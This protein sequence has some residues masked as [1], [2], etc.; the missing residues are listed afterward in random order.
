MPS[1]EFF[2][3][4]SQT[5]NM[6]GWMVWL[7]AL[8]IGGYVVTKTLVALPP[9]EGRAALEFFTRT[10]EPIVI[11][12][13]LLVMSSAVMASTIF[14]P[15]DSIW[16]LYATWYGRT[17]VV[18]LVLAVMMFLRSRQRFA[19]L[20]NLLWDKNDSLH[21]RASAIVRNGLIVD[22]CGFGAVLACMELMTIG[23]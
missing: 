19:R 16:N 3:L 10:A 6:F 21:P 11:G 22:L 1:S 18:G 2:E 23:L 13:S 4:L 9:R 8:S 17:A 14:G 5:L 20:K 12:A 15:I 7:G